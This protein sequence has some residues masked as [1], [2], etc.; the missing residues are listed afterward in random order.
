M[1]DFGR[2]V[3]EQFAAELRAFLDE[4]Y[5]RELR[6][7]RF[8]RPF[9]W[10]F[11]RK[12][13]AWQIE[14]LPDAGAAEMNAFAQEMERADV[15]VNSNATVLVAKTLATIGA[16]EQKKEVLPRM[17]N[18]EIVCVLG[19]TEPDSGSD[20]A[21]A[22]T[23]AD[24][25]GDEWVINGQKMF[26]SRAEIGTHVFLLTRTNPQVPKHKG[27]TLFL[28][29]LDTPGIEIREIKT[30]RG[31]RT[32]MTFYTDV[33]VP[34]SCRVGDVDGGWSVMRVA[35]DLEHLAGAKYDLG[36]KNEIELQVL[37]KANSTSGW[38]ERLE[39]VLRRTLEWA[40]SAK[41]ADGSSVIADP[42]VRERLARG[43]IEVEVSRLLR[44]RNDDVARMPGVG[45]GAKL[46]ATEAHQRVTSDLIDLVGPVGLLQHTSN[47]AIA[48]GWPEYGFR[49]SQVSTIAGGSSE[50]QRDVV[51]ER[52]LGL[53]R[54]R[55]ATQ[56]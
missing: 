4:N 40:C 47:E 7:N 23:R 21:A 6:E 15:V 30:L 2:E 10:D 44:D 28:V 27:L 53:V 32:N 25:D 46:Y 12:F 1:M 50:V 14:H 54:M 24:R 37:E 11:H 42:S 29:P 56:G 49:D 52:R 16:V 22:K 3:N 8:D 41:R 26:T 38:I 9:D 31:H 13:T 39:P 34:D 18:G 48:G 51:A 5:P 55:P 20:V 19:Y 35:L 17:L 33:R 36:L 45:N 43:A